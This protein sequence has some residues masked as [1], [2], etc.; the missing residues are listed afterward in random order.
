MYR[1]YDVGSVVFR[2]LHAD[3]E[4]GICT[5]YPPFETLPPECNPIPRHGFS[6]DCSSSQK[7]GQ[8]SAAGA[9][10][11][12]PPKPPSAFTALLVA[13]GALFAVGRKRRGARRR[14]RP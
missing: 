11:G 8:C 7:E 10:E 9:V 1:H 13:V 14:E 6:P 3:D 12:S 4:K 2:D 5:A